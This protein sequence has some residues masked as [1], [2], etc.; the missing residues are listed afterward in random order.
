MNY[1]INWKCVSL[2]KLLHSWY[3]LATTS[4]FL[5]ALGILSYCV[6]VCVCVYLRVCV[7][8]TRR[9]ATHD[10]MWCEVAVWAGPLAIYLLVV[11]CSAD[12]WK[13]I[14]IY[15]YMVIYYPVD[16]KYFIS[17]ITLLQNSQ[18]SQLLEVLYTQCIIFFLFFLHT[19]T[20]ITCL[21]LFLIFFTHADHAMKILKH[22]LKGSTYSI[23][24]EISRNK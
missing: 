13:R 17:S 19:S 7:D 2:Y 10:V 15:I 1:F 12:P 21:Y 23:W 5:F 16:K 18:N 3:W 8:A 11:Q 4:Y 22:H 14:Y 20:S 6:C 9:D 24:T